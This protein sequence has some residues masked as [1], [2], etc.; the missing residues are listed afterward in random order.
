MP[1]KPASDPM[2]PDLSGPCLDHA[3]LPMATLDGATHIARYVNPAFCRLVNKANDE[4]V[5]KRFREMLPGQDKCLALLGRVYRTGTSESYTEQEHSDPRPVFRSYTVWPVMAPEHT[6]GVMLQVIETPN[7][8]E[9]TL[10]MNEAL[11]V[12]SLRQHELTAAANAS[13][14]ARK[15]AQAALRRANEVLEARVSER[16]HEL[17][18]ANVKL[19][20]EAED[21]E[22][23]EEVL[24]QS[25]K[26]E[27]IGQL[28]GGI[29][30]D[31]NN[32][33]QGISG[34]LELMRTR[35]AQGRTAEF[36]RYI[37]TALGSANRAAALTHRLLAFSRRQTLD[38]MPTDV[39]RLVG[40]ML[41][42]FGRTVEPSIQITTT[43]AGELWMALCDPNQLENALLNLV[44]N[45]RDAMPDGGHLI[46]ETAKT[47]FPEQRRSPRGPPSQDVPPGEYVALSVA[48]TGTGMTPEVIARAFDP[49]FTT[50]PLGQGTGLGL[51]MIHGFVQQSGGQLRLLSRVGQGTTVTIYLPQ[52]LAARDGEEEVEA[53]VK[54]LA[55][56][57]N[58]VV[59]VVSDEPAVR[60]IIAEVLS[61]LGYTM[62]EA[63]NGRSG[64][65]ILESKTRIDLLLTD[66]GLPGGMNGRQLADAARQRRP[67]LKVLFIT[68][69]AESVVA[70][71]DRMEQGMQVMTK[72][73]TVD[74]LAVG[75]Q[76]MIS[77]RPVN[78]MAK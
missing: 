76:G 37:E 72:P 6:V 30:H 64:L 2:P 67:G 21:R 45:A 29:A 7:L 46:I 14:T 9:K 26:M 57:V 17:T 54:C 15:Q 31:F 20:A 66:V 18:V 40:G 44:I 23:V 13:N 74:A 25:Q 60:M 34:S 5:G 77:D 8:Y 56:T 63:A 58:T 78:G 70:G 38:P 1:E 10:A 52:Y 59:L 42:L 32:L 16:T 51:S 71:N 24:R 61:D 27:A 4:L 3:P 53:A 19:R 28:T 49:F 33:L 11:I 39:N 68:G 55:A 22:R 36:G 35:A 73:F 69:Y 41:E 47:N 12:G 62:V 65:H 75:I 43:L 50:K 48:D